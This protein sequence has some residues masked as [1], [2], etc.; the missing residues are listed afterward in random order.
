[1]KKVLF[2]FGQKNF[3][4]LCIK[5]KLSKLQLFSIQI[6]IESLK[7]TYLI[8]LFSSLTKLYLLDFDSLIF[9]LII[10]LL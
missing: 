8:Q 4:N 9:F 3:L 10:F 2:G 1:M 6:I 5:W 7:S